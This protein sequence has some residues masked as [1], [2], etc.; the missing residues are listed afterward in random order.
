MSASVGEAMFVV[1]RPGR[2]WERGSNRVLCPYFISPNHGI[3]L[4]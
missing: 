3:F 4:K 2:E 1:H